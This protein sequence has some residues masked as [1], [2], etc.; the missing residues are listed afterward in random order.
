MVGEE[1]GVHR[2]YSDFRKAF[3]SILVV[4]Y[5]VILVGR[6]VAGWLARPVLTNGSSSFWTEMTNGMP[7]NSVWDLVLFTLRNWAITKPFK[8]DKCKVL[9]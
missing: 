5:T 8:K 7:H 9:H 3:N 2:V 1:N 4:V 6:F